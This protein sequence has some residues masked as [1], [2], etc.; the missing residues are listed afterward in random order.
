MAATRR[1]EAK[2]VV[3]ATIESDNHADTWCFGPNF[4]MDHFTGQTCSVSGYDKKIKST[5]ICIGTGLTM[6][7]DPNSGKLQLLQVN[8][9]L[10][11]RHIL[12]H[13]LANPNQCRSFG[14][15][16]C[17]DA[18]DQHRSLGIECKNP[19][20]SIPFVMD[21]STAL[22]ETRTPT[23]DEIK[24]YFDDRIILTDSNT[25]DPVDLVVPRK[26]SAIG[27]ISNTSTV[28]KIKQ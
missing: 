25:W 16:W 15:S 27:A 18:W 1:E 5:E 8:Q 20:L 6:W 3:S 4:V 11:M 12:D 13:T 2:P 22:F 19:D 10:D 7:T 26:V 24:D 17:D 23:E 21:G 9:G 14:V 28:H